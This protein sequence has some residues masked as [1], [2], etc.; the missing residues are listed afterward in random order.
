MGLA[1]WGEAGS[2]RQAVPLEEQA[3]DYAASRAWLVG[4]SGE[5]QQVVLGRD[6]IVSASGGPRSS[7]VDA[8][9]IFL[10][11]GIHLPGFG[12]DDFAGVDL[13][14]KIAVVI[15]GGPAGIHE[16]GR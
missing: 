14:G 8:P 9:L 10:G 11:Y 5:K 3:I 4:R 2:Y 1:P 6:M 15:G 12:H 13:R 7:A 16:D